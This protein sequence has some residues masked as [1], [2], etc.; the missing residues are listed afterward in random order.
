MRGDLRRVENEQG[1]PSSIVRLPS[2][3]FCPFSHLQRPMQMKLVMRSNTC[4]PRLIK[5]SRRNRSSIAKKELYKAFTILH[6]YDDQSA[7]AKVPQE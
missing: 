7:R 2:K 1:K 3:H 6:W 5:G 4:P